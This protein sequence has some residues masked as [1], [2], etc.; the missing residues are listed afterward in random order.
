M[1]RD[2]L[3]LLREK[4]RAPRPNCRELVVVRVGGLR[5]FPA[6]CLDKHEGG[7][8]LELPV[9]NVLQVGEMVEIGSVMTGRVAWIRRTGSSRQ[10][11]IAG[12]VHVVQERRQYVRVPVKMTALCQDVPA[13]VRDLSLNGLR[14]EMPVKP[15]A[16]SKCDL[17]LKLPD[18]PLSLKAEVVATRPTLT[19]HLVRLRIPSL[20]A[21]AA[22][23]L[24]AY[25]AGAL[26]N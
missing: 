17:H 4:R 21:S 18:S 8:R 1:Q 3:E 10:A 26:R 15:Q 7:M 6:T 12:K 19:S 24:S 14:L 20:D 22:Q 11:G 25:L 13:R 9:G 23:R 2:T 16:G 5:S